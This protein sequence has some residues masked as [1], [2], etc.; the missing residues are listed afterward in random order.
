MGCGRGGPGL[1]LAARAHAALVG[2]DFSPVAIAQACHRAAPFAADAA[3]AVADLAR[4]PFTGQCVDR[5]LALDALQYA[6]DRVAAARQALRILKPGGRLVL[7]GW[8]PHTRGSER[9]PPRHRHTDCRSGGECGG[10]EH[11]HGE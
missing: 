11:E 7:T 2:I 1:W 8:H 4:L 9:L 5:A 10:D 3:F 6:P